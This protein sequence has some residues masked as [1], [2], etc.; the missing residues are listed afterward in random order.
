MFS[1]CP[2]QETNVEKQSDFSREG[3]CQW[4]QRANTLPSHSREPTDSTHLSLTEQQIYSHP[5]I[6]TL[7]NNC[8]TL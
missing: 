6:S 7:L 8:N 1:S 2:Q 5:I 4:L 3:K